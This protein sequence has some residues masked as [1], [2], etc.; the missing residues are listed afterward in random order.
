VEW[1][2]VGVC[3]GMGRSEVGVW[4]WECG[5]GVGG[6]VGVGYGSGVGRSVGMWSGIGVWE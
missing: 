6:S 1:S 4:E 5:S 2:G 3:S